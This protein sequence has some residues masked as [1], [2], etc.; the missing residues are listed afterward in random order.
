MTENEVWKGVVGYEGFYQVS[1]KGNV[2]SV[3]RVDSR[4]HRRRGRM[5]K[6]KY[7]RGGYLTVNL[8]KNGKPKTKTVHR[9]VA[10]T[11][12][13]NLSGLSQVN[14]RDEIKDN[15]NVENLEWC[16]ARYNSNHGTRNERMA[17]AQSKKVRA[18]NAKTGD[19][20]EFNSTAEAGRKGYHCGVVSMACRG[21][22]K[23][24]TGKLVGGDG[25]TYRGYRWSYEVEE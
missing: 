20:V 8:C 17:Q 6:P 21:T 25:R 16:D 13:P 24:R 18:V 22:Y 12:L 1:N 10:E 19:V 7:N 2:Y 4:G 5:L 11:F 9:L 3:E 23:N 15:N 14:H